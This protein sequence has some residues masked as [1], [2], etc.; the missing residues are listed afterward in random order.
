MTRP[1]PVFLFAAVAFC[2]LP[3]LAAAPLKIDQAGVVKE[4]TECRKLTDGVQR[5]AC[6][7]AAV[8]KM[9]T[10]QAKGDL[11]T[12]DREQR[13][14]IRRQAFGLT[15][16][17]LSVFDK[18]EKAE[19]ISVQT[20]KVESAS[21]NADRRW[22]IRLEGGQVWRQ[23]DDNSLF[24]SPHAGSEAVVRKGALGS[25]NMKIDGQQQIKVHRD[26]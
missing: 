25:F 10:A 5:L 3:A 19:D 4:V 6:Y 18:G 9:E 14:T 13:S 20:F 11:V 26:Q 24:K 15:L 1:S 21:M 7:D 16:P 2:A 12:V 23:I 22:I 8:A 17:S